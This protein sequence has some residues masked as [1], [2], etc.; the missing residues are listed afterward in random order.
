MNRNF[1][2]T[3]TGMIVLAGALLLA[4]VGLWQVLSDFFR[5]SERPPIRVGNGDSLEI[6]TQ[7]GRWKRDRQKI[8]QENTDGRTPTVLVVTITGAANC[9]DPLV[10]D[11]LAISYGRRTIDVALSRFKK[12]VELDVHRDGELLV[13]DRIVLVDHKSGRRLTSA[14]LKRRVNG[15]TATTTCTFDAVENQANA[16]DLQP[17]SQVE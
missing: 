3:R 8:K 7:G 4:G 5:Q 11:E 1:W 12:T 10:A 15:T 13:G 6:T 14:T 2:R 9:P 17:K 16:I